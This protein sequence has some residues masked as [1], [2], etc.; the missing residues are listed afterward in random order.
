MQKQVC[1]R[2]VALLYAAVAAIDVVV[3]VYDFLTV[4]FFVCQ[5]S[6]K[7]TQCSSY[8]LEQALSNGLGDHTSILCTQ[9]RRVATMSVAERVADELAEPAIG[10][11][12]GYQIRMEARTT[13]ETRLLFCTTGVVLRRLIE[14]PTLQG[15]SHGTLE[16]DSILLHIYLVKFVNL[17]LTLLYT[18]W[19]HNISVVVVD[20]VHER[21]VSV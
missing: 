14:D 12:V 17:I 13:A 18:D 5:G 19:I 2:S 3:A 11:L 6:G 8:I 10:K 20:E 15:I 21:Q 9:P 4:P 1:N 16:D 7:T